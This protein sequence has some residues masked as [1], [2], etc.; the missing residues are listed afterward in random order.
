MTPH[1]P[2]TIRAFYAEGD[3]TAEAENTAA[4][5][6]AV[7]AVAA[8][9][10][11]ERGS[12][13]GRV[14]AASSSAYEVMEFQPAQPEPQVRAANVF[15]RTWLPPGTRL[16]DHRPWPAALTAEGTGLLGCIPF[17]CWHSKSLTWL[18]RADRL[19][20]CVVCWCLQA[21]EAPA[22]DPQDFAGEGV[23]L[24]QLLARFRV[25]QQ[26]TLA[27]FKAVSVEDFGD[28][29]SLLPPNTALPAADKMTYLLA[30]LEVSEWQLDTLQSC[31]LLGTAAHGGVQQGFMLLGRAAPSG[32]QQ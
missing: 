18:Q 19:E 2:S 26:D 11:A 27:V 8:G 1:S 10:A 12:N 23:P 22:C 16:V 21:Q 20:A 9:V 3:Q 5:A 32:V 17:V 15:T 4:A 28:V 13:G 6:A 31:M 30:R 7:D 14:S 24:P 25:N 29:A